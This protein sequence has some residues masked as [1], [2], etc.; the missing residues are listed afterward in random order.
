MADS[1]EKPTKIAIE[2]A[3]Q[4]YPEGKR[5]LLEEIDKTT[6]GNWLVTIGFDHPGGTASVFRLGA[7]RIYK[8]FEVTSVGEV[9]RMKM[10]NV[11]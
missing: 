5:F 1:W 2:R 7:D 3:Q 10:R 6:N 11:P 8:E 4:L 9:V